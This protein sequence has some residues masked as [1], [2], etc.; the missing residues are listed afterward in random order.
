[1]G[2]KVGGTWV[3]TLHMCLD[4][5][6][7]KI[8]QLEISAYFLSGSWICYPLDSRIPV[9]GLRIHSSSCPWHLLINPEQG[10]NNLW[11]HLKNPLVTVLNFLAPSSKGLVPDHGIITLIFKL[12]LKGYP[13]DCWAVTNI[14]VPSDISEKLMPRSTNTITV[15]YDFYIHNN[16]AWS[17]GEMDLW[18][19]ELFARG[20]CVWGRGGGAGGGRYSRNIF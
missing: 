10:I 17:L 5:S 19:R 15:R 8:K 16:R 9:P 4:H 14:L 7:K 11:F 1:M 20:V 12:H 13:D 18:T 2:I 6:Q 3:N